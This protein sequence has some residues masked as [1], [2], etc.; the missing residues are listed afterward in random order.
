MPRGSL[1]FCFCACLCALVALIGVACVPAETD[2]QDATRYERDTTMGKIQER[3]VLRIA[4][5]GDLPP[6]SSSEEG[7]QPD[8]F[9][10]ELAGEIAEALRVE[11][12]YVVA[13]G[14]EA[15]DLVKAEEADLAFPMIGITERL[16][17]Q[18]NFSGPFWIGHTRLLVPEDSSIMSV[19]DLSGE[20]V[21][22][23]NEERTP[24]DIAALDASIETMDAAESDDCVTELR[25]GRSV[26]AVAPDVQLMALAT[27]LDGF[28][29]R[30]DD[31]STIGYG[32]AAPVEASDM[33]VFV[34]RVLT[35]SK[36]EGR[37]IEYY[38]EWLAPVSN[39]EGA[40]APDLTL[41]EVATLWP[42]DLE[43]EL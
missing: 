32:V 40:N 8:G 7:R 37:W 31:L 22:Q 25:E 19:D 35:D 28:E 42:R 38:E 6:F 5:P 39:L 30:G 18:N 17:R 3:G 11:I 12:D 26:A 43:P 36:S 24:V 23:Y 9:V 27:E 33:T 4:V 10:T 41:E 15:L 16:A 21:C 2:V 20:M 34:N 14:E 13:S 1:R 29:I